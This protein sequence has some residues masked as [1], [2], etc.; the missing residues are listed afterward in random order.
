MSSVLAS[1]ITACEAPL[2][3]RPVNRFRNDSLISNNSLTAGG[4]FIMCLKRTY[5]NK[6]EITVHI[7][8]VTEP[9]GGS[10]AATS[11]QQ[12]VPLQ[13]TQYAQFSSVLEY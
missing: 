12:A 8:I 9:A 10:I 13:T 3:S 2:G 5:T 11:R 1:R 4:G 6:S 7:M